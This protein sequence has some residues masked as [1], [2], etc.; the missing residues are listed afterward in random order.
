MSERKSSPF[1]F[2]VEG[3]V[4]AVADAAP[5]LDASEVIIPII[6]PA[7]SIIA[8]RAAATYLPKPD[9]RGQTVDARC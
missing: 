9:L 6:L 2:I 3:E 8:E 5:T 4:L 1:S 7:R